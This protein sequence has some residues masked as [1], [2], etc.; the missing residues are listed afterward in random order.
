MPKTKIS[1]FSA[2]ANSNTD[3]NSINIAEGCAPSNINDA[4]RE[5]MAELKDFQ[6]GTKGDSFNGPVGTT[7]AA[8]GAF[9]TLSST[10]N[11]TLGDASGDTVTINGTTTFVNVNPTLSAGTANGVLYL[12]GSKVATSGSALTFDGTNLALTGSS[13]TYKVPT[14]GGNLFDAGG[15]NGIYIQGTPTAYLGFYASGSE[16][17]RLTSTG[18]GIGTSSPSQRLH[19]TGSSSATTVGTSATI[20][21]TSS[22]GLSAPAG[23]VYLQAVIDSAT[24]GDRGTAL[25]FQTGRT[26]GI[27]ERMRIDSLGNLGLGVTPSAWVSG[28]TILQVKAGSSYGSVWGRNNSIRLMANAYYDGT[29]FKFSAT[30]IKPTLLNLADDGSFAFYTFNSGTAGGNATFTQAMTLDSSGNLG[31]GTTSPNYRLNV[32][33]SST[34]YIQLTNNSTGT[35]STD[36]FLI[37]NDGTGAYIVQRE[38]DFL[39]IWTNN[40]ERARITSGGDL[41]VGTTNTSPSA[42]VGAKIYPGGTMRCVNADSTSATETWSMYSTGAAAYRFWVN[43]AG[44]V[45]ATSTTISSVSDIRFKENIQDLDVGLNAVMALKPRKFDWK[46]GK[47]KDIKGDRGWIAQEF[48]QVFPDMIDEWRDTAPEGEE[49]YKSVRADLIPVLVKAIQEQQAIIEQL[50]ARLDAANL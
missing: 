12:N 1:E 10:G 50:K 17:M 26:A 7:T 38:N 40:T 43:W 16:Q 19:V 42:G 20:Q 15:N 49:P 29:N 21:I 28:D 5:L 31:I 8:A 27:A 36:G 46:A 9:T 33:G 47:G 30:G 6:A 44:T 37:G 32:N 18:L 45:F 22:T 48:E 39:S 11:T 41:L 24:P 35:A 14:A 13:P 34:G 25:A 23:D 4:I 3:I 2:T